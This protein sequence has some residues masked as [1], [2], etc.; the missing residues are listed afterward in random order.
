[1]EV[2]EALSRVEGFDNVATAILVEASAKAGQESAIV[3]ATDRYVLLTWANHLCSLILLRSSKD[4]DNDKSIKVDETI[5][6]SLVDCQASLLNA[7]LVDQLARRRV[8]QAAIASVRRTLR[9]HV[10]DAPLWI[11]S[12]LNKVTPAHRN[13]ALLGIVLDVVGNKVENKTAI[14]QYYVDTVLSAKQKLPNYVSTALSGFFS[15]ALTIED[16]QQLIVPVLEKMLLRSPEVALASLQELTHAVSF[17][18]S[19]MFKDKWM[20]PLKTQLVSTSEK[21]RADAAAAFVTLIQKSDDEEVIEAIVK[22]LLSLLT[23]GKVSTWGHRQIYYTQL[24]QFM[25][26]FDHIDDVLLQGAVTMLPK[27]NNET[28]FGSLVQLVVK[29]VFLRAS[30]DNGDVNK[31]AIQALS[32]GLENTKPALRQ[33]WYI[34]LGQSALT[35]SISPESSLAHHLSDI[36]AILIKHVQQQASTKATAATTGTS[37]GLLDAYI[38][39]TIIERARSWFVTSTDHEVNVLLAKSQYEAT[40]LKET[41]FLFA[42]KIVLKLTGESIQWYL[43]A[44]TAFTANNYVLPDTLQLL[45]GGAFIHFMLHGTMEERRLTDRVLRQCTESNPLLVTESIQRALLHWLPQMEK[46]QRVEGLRSDQITYRLVRILTA[47]TTFTAT[48]DASIRNKALVHFLLVAHYPLLGSKYTWTTLAQ[49]ANFD[50]SVLSGHVTQL[51]DQIIDGLCDSDKKTA[52]LRMVPTLIFVDADTFVPRLSELTVCYLKNQDPRNDTASTSTSIPSITD[53]DLAIWRTEPGTLY[54]DVLRRGPKIAE[55]KNRQSVTQKLSKEEQ[56]L[57]DTQLKKEST[58]RAYVQQW[59]DH[60]T[61]GLD[62]VQALMNGKTKVEASL[63]QLTPILLTILQQNGEALVGSQLADA[64]IA[65]SEGLSDRLGHARTTIA[66]AILRVFNA[67]MIHEEWQREPL[68]ELV[69]RALY[70]IRFATEQK[71]LLPGS[72]SYG[73]PLIQRVIEHNGIGYPEGFVEVLDDET[74]VTEKTTEQT[75]VSMDILRFHAQSG[76]QSL[77]PRREILASLLVVIRDYS[78]LMHQAK[79]TLETFCDGMAED[80]TRYE[81]DT[82]YEALLWSSEMVRMACLDALSS[83]DLNPFGYSRELWTAC[84]DEDSTI[85]ATATA[86]WTEAQL[87]VPSNYLDGLLDLIIHGASVIRKSAGRALA[88]A[89]QQYPSTLQSTLNA[90]YKEYAELAVAAIPKYDKFGLV[91]PETVDQKDPWEARVSLGHAIKACVPLLT[92]TELQSLFSFLLAGEALGDKEEGVRQ[93]MLEAGNTAI[94]LHGKDQLPLMTVF[95][96]YL[97]SPAKASEVHDRIREGAVVLYGSMAQFLDKTDPRIR[98]VVDRLIDTLKTPSESVQLAVSECISPLVKSMK[99]TAPGLVDRLVDRMLHAKKY[100]ERRGCAFGLAGV[101]KGYGI[102]LLKECHIMSTLK[103]AAEDKKHIYTRQGSMLAFEAFAQLLGRLFEPYVIQVVPLLLSGFG[104]SSKDV[105]DATIEAAR[106]IMSKISGHCVKLIMPSLMMGLQ[107]R[108]WRTQRGSVELLGA[109]AY[110]APKQLSVSLPHIVPRLVEVLNDAHQQVQESAKEALLN[111]GQVISN[112]E[113]QDLVPTLMVALCDPDTKTNTAL[114]ALLETSF[115][116]YIDAPSLALIMPIIQRGLCERGTQVKRKSAQIIGNLSSLTSAKDFTP[117]LT[118][119]MPGLR[120]VLVDPVPSA[121]ATAAMALGVLVQR[122]GEEQFPELVPQLLQTLKSDTSGVDRQGAA[123]GL[124][125]V[126]AGLGIQRLDELLPDMIANTSSSKAY[127]RE[128]FVS[129][130]IYLP[131]T[132]GTRFQP[133]LGQIIPP[134]LARLADES[135]YVREASLKAGQII[136]DHFSSTAVELLLPELERGLFEENWRIRH[137]SVQLMGDLLYKMTGLQVKSLT[138]VASQPVNMAASSNPDGEAEAEEE[139][140]VM[141]TEEGRKALVDALGQQRRNSVLAAL[142]VVRSDISSVVRQAAVMVWK[143]IVFNTPRT[144]KEILPNIMEIVLKHLASPIELLRREAAATLGDLVRKLG[145]SILLRIIP[146]LQTSLASDDSHQR[147][148]ACIG[149]SE[150]M[151]T[152][153]KIHVLEEI[154]TMVPIIRSG[155]CD[156]TPQVREAAAQAFDVLHGLVGP[157][158]VDDIIP[159]LLNQLHAGESHALEG[160]KE[161]MTVRASVVFPVL[162][163]TLV[164]VPMTEFNANALGALISVAGNAL[165]RRLDLVL[166]A[167]MASLNQ[168]DESA[169][170]AVQNTIEVLVTNI[171]DEDAVHALMMRLFEKMRKQQDIAEESDEDTKAVVDHNSVKPATCRVLASFA[172]SNPEGVGRYISDWLRI[173]IDFYVVDNELTKAASNAVDALIKSQPKS[174]LD[175]YINTARASIRRAVEALSETSS[176]LLPGLCLPK[177]I[178][179]FLSIYLQGLMNGTADVREVSVLGIGELIEHTSQ[180]ALK[181]YVT[182]VTGPLIRVI[183]ERYPAPV[184]AAILQTLGILLNKVSILLKPF[185]PQLQRTFIKSLSD[186]DGAVRSHAASALGILITLQTRVDTLIVELCTGIRTTSSHGIRETMLN[187]LYSVIAKAGAAMNETCRQSVEKVIAECLTDSTTTIQV[188]AAR[189][190]GAYGSTVEPAQSEPLFR[191]LIL[192]G[193]EE[194]AFDLPAI[195]GIDA[196]LIEEPVYFEQ[197]NVADAI[198]RRVLL[199]AK[200]ADYQVIEMTAYVLGRL[201]ACPAY[202]QND[203]A[204]LLWDSLIALITGPYGNDVR[205]AALVAVKRVAKHHHQETITPDLLQLI[206]PAVL[207]QLKDRSTPVKL[208]AERTLLYVLALQNNDDVFERFNETGDANIVKTLADYHRRVLSKTAITAREDG[209][210][211]GDEGNEDGLLRR[212]NKMTTPSHADTST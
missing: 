163:P 68:K 19:T 4:G 185:L 30:T 83:W 102:S 186:T 210:N 164:Q 131:V 40:L 60:L 205:Q 65:L 169:V 96:K 122:L 166:D 32:K 9:Q 189:C 15:Q 51:I 80:V 105:R 31:T 130:L 200:D 133:Y 49:R 98:S 209:Q 127:V 114:S 24:S 16:T 66:R 109:M 113:I 93:S 75:M 135:D 143:S 38:A 146:L 137:S 129:L 187:A 118:H 173:L 155:V 147:Q 183:G 14:I 182:Q 198:I 184:K 33:A 136:V 77:M 90:I 180:S 36:I 20:N 72:F 82:L 107:D 43:Q 100:A 176:T 112:P 54:V 41:S 204:K 87:K 115:I 188:A 201:L 126:I 67:Q 110:C 12:L 159:A 193:N 124:S 104:D 7:L 55:D 103:E 63:T 132:F 150:V 47:A 69:I 76:D 145:E 70:R 190:L 212:G 95:E 171:E 154:D 181:A 18:V 45:Y 89:V 156:T 94:K 177:G 59:Y 97:K 157:R 162:V 152:A 22:D 165:S 123:Q 6:Q 62:L 56:A 149:L 23:T 2:L 111:F 61:R 28:A 26:R 42:E 148:G 139:V 39:V 13:L 78:K 128:G 25:D 88:D 44:I 3:A 73:Y 119:L 207:S 134:I 196:L 1:M 5:W 81:I 197:V 86:C 57:V 91:I 121:R 92:S 48:C 191:A 199:T 161:I 101:V 175:R 37:T 10:K 117:Y 17:D 138:A 174:E 140:T 46:G 120:E 195:L 29:G 125:E 168:S 170:S 142:Y 84:H 167:L 116:H 158:A 160:L 141:I 206:V 192:A 27:E 202:R 178:A 52:C 79:E 50:F 179:P 99:E 172:H 106:M 35:Q 64:F 58:I 208:A 74:G 85:A 203:S 11:Q 144:I 8:Q 71:P 108:Q 34:A 211:S 194:E 151:Q 21:V 53:D 153:G